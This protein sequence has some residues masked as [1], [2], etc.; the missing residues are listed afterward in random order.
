MRLE[1]K[2]FKLYIILFVILGIISFAGCY[3][4]IYV[5]EYH[6]K[7]Y[8]NEE[9]KTYEENNDYYAEDDSTYSDST[10]ADSNYYDEEQPTITGEIIIMIIILMA[11]ITNPF[12]E[13]IIGDIIPVIVSA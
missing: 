9:A 10:Y 5:P 6:K 13:N 11:H 2:D 7:K 3:T 12:T 8:E 1:M 4:Q